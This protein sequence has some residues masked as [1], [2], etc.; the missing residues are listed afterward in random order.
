MI[1][2]RN[3]GYFVTACRSPTLGKAAASLEISQS[4][5]SMTLKA[6][7]SELGVALFTRVNGGL[8]PT[9]AARWLHRMSLPLLEAEEFARRWLQQTQPKPA[10]LLTLDMGMSFTS[11]QYDAAIARALHL[12]ARKEPG[13]MTRVRW[14]DD[15]P[16]IPLRAEKLASHASTAEARIH[17]SVSPGAVKPPKGSVLLLR[18]PWVLA[19]RVPSGTRAPLAA[20]DLLG[21]RLIVPTLSPQLLEEADRYFGEIGNTGV[22]FVSEH[23]GDLPA[24]MEAFPDATVFVPASLVTG[25]LGLLNVQA[26]PA[27]PPLELN[28]V[29]SASGLGT[30]DSGLMKL[31][32]RAF[33]A[34][35]RVPTP[36]PVLSVRQLRYFNATYRLRRIS[37]AAHSL[38]AAQPSLSE[39]I[40][41]IERTLKGT[42]FVRKA[43]GVVP[44]AKGDQ[45]A[46]LAREIEERWRLVAQREVPEAMPLVRRIS[47]GILP[48]VSAHGHLLTRITEV[49]IQV[50]S[51]FPALKFSIR[52]ASNSV[53][54][55]WVLR[56][57][58][59][60][61]IV[62]T[63]LPRL[64]RLPLGSSEELA[65]IA[66]AGH[67]LL[68]SGP[69]A[70][71]QLV[72]Q[73]LVL[74]SMRF[75]LRQLLSSA[76]D[77]RGLKVHPLMEIDALS[78]LVA[79]LPQAR[80]ATVLPPSAVW[81]EIESGE[82]T[83]H[84]IRDPAIARRMFVI[85][86][87]E[88]TLNVPE[89]DFVDRLRKSLSASSPSK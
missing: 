47:L 64:P 57:L 21:G 77:E 75:G 51:R 84:P 14:A 35:G 87:G 46:P 71:E 59:D 16:Q 62:E 63:A 66:H 10:R 2:L 50:Q 88:R 24:A 36:H 73:P 8:Y 13:M 11:G 79:M 54:Q 48:S 86:S 5:L 27:D 33:D 39:Q 37:A 42:L 1:E 31:L 53:L 81:R 20:R 26:I 82:L 17:F 4:T 70:L 6:L 41:K 69:I 23:P 19:R 61:A 29:A 15:A 18:E 72:Q 78:M 45:F 85:Y 22:S 89:R 60:I 80:V 28:V 40:H 67:K 68:P 43:D 83:S 49:A 76:C 52:E 7:E 9:T 38:N 55:D 30:A 65:A 3:L 25:R 44:T 58:V 34:K 56:G 12:F 32:R 74:P